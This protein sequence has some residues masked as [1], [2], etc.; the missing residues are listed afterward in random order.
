[1]LACSMLSILSQ[2]QLT[3]NERNTLVDARESHKIGDHLTT[4]QLLQPI[5]HTHTEHPEV[6]YLL[7]DAAFNLASYKKESV[8]YLKKAADLGYLDSYG[9][10]AKLLL[11][12]NRPEE[13]I[14]WLD[15]IPAD[16]QTA[17]TRLIRKHSEN[18][19][20]LE[21][22]DLPVVINWLGPEVNTE[23]AEHTP[24]ISYDNET[25]FFTSRRPFGDNSITDL[26][27]QFDENI[28]QTNHTE[29]GWIDAFPLPGSI[30]DDLND[31][32]VALSPGADEMLV[33]KTK[34]DLAS[35]DLWLAMLDGSEW[36]LNNRLETPIN[37]KFIENSASYNRNTNIYYISSDRP[38]GYGGF[39]IYRIVRFGNGDLSEPQ[40]LGPEI[41]S[42]YDEI[43]PFLLPDGQTLYFSS[44]GERS[45][46]GFDIFMSKSLLN[47]NW[48]EPENLGRPICT[49]G[50]DLHI[51]VSWKGGV[52]Y[53]TRAQSALSGNL[54]I[55]R[56]NLPGFDISANVFRVK[57]E[58]V[59]GNK[60]IDV[61]MFTDDFSEMIGTYSPNQNGEFIIV[62][63][64]G[65]RGIL[66]IL[67]DDFEP[68][69][70]ELEYDDEEDGIVEIP[71]SVELEF[72]HD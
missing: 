31:A 21:S 6:N 54:D 43:S 51:N 27:G 47:D 45:I 57:F 62:L 39:D 60:N 44:N 2:A 17:E 32:T 18:A 69:E 41:N 49:T 28:Y 14:Q 16:K 13:A 19:Q 11:T 48:T 67:H 36:K 65:E 4:W 15:K 30:N 3:K 52:A 68:F 63:L 64:P 40:N 33:F 70:V 71:L 61:S 5:V 66:E 7:G 59:I 37:S 58:N 9:P 42:E 29:L 72:K 26:T 10:Y 46:G 50:D 8:Q 35:S 22:T 12:L 53:F 25:L 24:L 56:S 20:M 23:F 38:G 55:V 1:M 34:R